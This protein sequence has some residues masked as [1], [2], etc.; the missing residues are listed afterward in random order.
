M[1]RSARRPRRS[2]RTSTRRCHAVSETA[3]RRRRGALTIEVNR[4]GCLAINGDDLDTMLGESLNHVRRRYLRDAEWVVAMDNTRPVGVAAYHPVP[5]DVRLVL[6][7]LLDPELSA[8]DAMR[9]ANLLL[10]TVELRAGES[11]ACCVMVVFNAGVT[12]RPF[13]RRGY[14]TVAIDAA[15]AWVQKRL[16]PVV[17]PKAAMRR[18]H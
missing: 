2:S 17:R 15:T 3:G 1:P 18:I 13:E 14:R 9:V 6:E 10:S 11:G 12:R 8:P 5:S 16:M 4:G 7:F